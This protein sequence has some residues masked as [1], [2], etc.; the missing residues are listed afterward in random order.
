LAFH[1]PA[2]GLE[3]EHEDLRLQERGRDVLAFLRLLALEQGDHDA[4]RAEQPGAEVR[5]W[6]PDPYRSLPRQASDRH[7]AAHALRD[8]VEAGPA[9]IGSVL[10][11][12]RNAA[13]DDLG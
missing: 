13:E 3:V 9:R 12:A 11:E 6:N 4:E 10:A 1:Q 2:R 8:L 7:Q 5:D